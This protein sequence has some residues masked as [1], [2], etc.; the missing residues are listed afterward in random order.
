MGRKSI[1]KPVIILGFANDQVNYLPLLRKE[2][3]EIYNILRPLNDK[4]AIQVERE[5]RF[6]VDDFF[7]LFNHYDNRIELFH[8]G[9]HADEQVLFFDRESAYAG[10]LAGR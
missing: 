5:S 6:T 3:E 8:Y 7:Y 4:G 2:E 10:G 1:Y 9:G